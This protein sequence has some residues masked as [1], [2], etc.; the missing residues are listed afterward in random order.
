MHFR[1]NVSILHFCW[2]TQKHLQILAQN[3]Y[4]YQWLIQAVAYI[5]IKE[6]EE[7]KRAGTLLKLKKKNVKRVLKESGKRKTPF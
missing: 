1:M 7:K 4:I 6:E 2:L 3:H 5:V